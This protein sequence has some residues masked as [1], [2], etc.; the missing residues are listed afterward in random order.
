MDESRGQLYLNLILE[1]HDFA[2]NLN[3]Q[4][5]RH[6]VTVPPT[7]VVVASHI[8]DGRT[9]INS[10][11]SGVPLFLLHPRR[12]CPVL[13]YCLR[14]FHDDAHFISI[15]R[16]PCHG[17]L[18]MEPSGRDIIQRVLPRDTGERMRQVHPRTN[19]H[20]AG[21]QGEARIPQHHH[22][23]HRHAPARRVPGKYDRGRRHRLEQEKVRREAVLQPTGEG[24]LRREAE[25]GREDPGLQLPGVPLHL[26]PVL[27]HAPEEV[28]PAVDVQHHAGPA[29]SVPL[30]LLVVGPH[31]DPLRL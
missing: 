6:H 29:V 13:A 8:R 26:V 27:V 16:R 30:A 23:G 24:E 12:L 11:R 7:I 10:R 4:H 3:G 2:I 22:H 17:R 28:C 21:G 9:T 31:L 18:L 25:L 20:R 19:Q 1:L 14:L 15:R 5:P